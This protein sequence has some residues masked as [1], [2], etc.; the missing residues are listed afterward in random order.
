MLLLKA[1][2]RDS[3]WGFK[4]KLQT[5]PMPYHLASQWGA[6]A[7]HQCRIQ[8]VRWTG[9]E[10]NPKFMKFGTTYRRPYVPPKALVRLSMSRFIQ[11]IFANKS[12]NRRKPNKCKVFAPTFSGWTT[13]TFIEQIVSATHR[14]PF[15]KVWLSYVC[16]PPRAK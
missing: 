8:G 5:N 13:P 15:G 12:W 16:W 9:T 6:S 4:C 3:I 10:Q 14:S 7:R 1:A 2:R 11:Q